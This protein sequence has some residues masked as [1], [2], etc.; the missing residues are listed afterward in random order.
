MHEVPIESKQQPQSG[1][2]CA[3]HVVK[4]PSK[5]MRAIYIYMCIYMFICKEL[6]EETGRS[7]GLIFGM[8]GYFW[9]GTDKFES[10]NFFTHL[11]KL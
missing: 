6:I 8:W 10:W 3:K 5:R 2:C 7:P 11:T 1:C 9:P 4:Q